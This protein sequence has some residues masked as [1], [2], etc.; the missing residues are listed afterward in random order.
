MDFTG[1]ALCLGLSL[2]QP[3][4]PGPCCH[5]AFSFIASLFSL[6]RGSP[7]GIPVLVA[8]RLLQAIACTQCSPVTQTLLVPLRRVPRAAACPQG[9]P[10]CS[11]GPHWHRKPKHTRS[12]PCR[13]P[14]APSCSSPPRST[15]PDCPHSHNFIFSHRM[16][17]SKCSLGRGESSFACLI[18]RS[19]K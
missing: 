14:A 18:F 5:S 11:A 7:A 17:I 2:P 6:C 8:A 12:V 15:S 9:Q 19:C 13:G 10:S 3:G 1:T 4:Y 16:L